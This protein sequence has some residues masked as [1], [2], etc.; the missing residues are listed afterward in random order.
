MVIQTIKSHLAEAIIVVIFYLMIYNRGIKVIIS[1]QKKQL[2]SLLS[3][4]C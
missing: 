1:V 3:R 4:L 2:K